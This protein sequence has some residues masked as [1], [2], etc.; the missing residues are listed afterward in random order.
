LLDDASL[1]EGYVKSVPPV[2]YD[3]IKSLDTPVTIIYPD[4]KNLAKNV[5]ADDG[6]V[7]IRIA[8]DKFCKQMIAGFGKPVV[9]TS[10]NIS[11]QPVPLAYSKISKEIKMNVDHIV[12]Y[13]RDVV[14]QVRPSTIIKIEADGGFQI[15]R[16]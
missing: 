11:G 10:A 3:L 12:D 7:A 14:V 8:S 16:I 9:S 2:T 15:I 1:L 6:S 13:N 4:A 5:I